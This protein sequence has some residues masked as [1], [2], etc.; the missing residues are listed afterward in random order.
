M[1]P[2]FVSHQVLRSLVLF[3]ETKGLKRAD[4]LHQLRCDEQALHQPS[5]SFHLGH[6]HRLM[7]WAHQQL[8][9]A[10]IGL[11]FG[12]QLDLERWGVLGHLAAVSPDLHRVIDYGRRFHPLVRHTQSL[13][14]H[15][16]AQTL[17]LDLGPT[18]SHCYYVI[19]ELFASWLSFARMYVLQ[20]EQLTP[21][22]VHL[23]RSPPN[24]TKEQRIYEN[25]FKCPVYFNS[26]TNS[27]TIAR[28]LLGQPLKQP[29]TTLEQLL[30]H[31]AQQQLDA[32][33]DLR[34]KVKQQLVAH[35]P[36]RLN[37]EQAAQLCA[38]PTRTLQRHLAQQQTSFSQLLDEARARLALQLFE[39]GYKA[40][41][42]ATKLGF[43]EQSA[44]QRA[45]KRWYGTSP[46]R[47][48]ITKNNLK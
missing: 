16:R 41:D 42:I 4:A 6:Y 2:S 22:A 39:S 43:S 46:K 40:I 3:L 28:V 12:V 18:Q 8:N 32:R 27:M 26:S 1:S 35:L 25:V 29:D 10:H 45:F 21:V 17:T 34:E 7:L 30:L 33:F 38:V 37:V 44:L 19:D 5:E 20:A 15:Q 36:Q 48:L 47:Y 13:T 23:M 14:F 24:N 9:C 11:Y 31:Q